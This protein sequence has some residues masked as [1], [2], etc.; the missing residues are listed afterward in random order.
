MSPTASNT[1]RRGLPQ[2][3]AFEYD[4]VT[5][6]VLDDSIAADLERIADGTKGEFDVRSRSLDDRRWVVRYARGRRAQ[7]ILPVRTGHG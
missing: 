7:G 1:Q 6:T 4:R 2:A 3:V 5:W